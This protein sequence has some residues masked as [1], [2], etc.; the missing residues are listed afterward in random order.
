MMTQVKRHRMFSL[1]SARSWTRVLCV[2]GTP[3]LLSITPASG[4][5]QTVDCAVTDSAAVFRINT[6]KGLM[7]R[8]EPEFRAAFTR[9]QIPIVTD[10]SAIVFVADNRVC[11]KVRASFNAHLTSFGATRPAATQVIVIKVGN[12]YVVRDTYDDPSEWQ[13]EM[14]MS[15]QYKVLS[16]YGA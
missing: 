1:R 12:V 8:P 14:V 16:A 7:L 2:V 4:S 3:V 6:I 13:Y 9:E 10:T 11:S 5:S 15:R